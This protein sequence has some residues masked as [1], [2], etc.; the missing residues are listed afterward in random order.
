MRNATTIEVTACFQCRYGD[1]AECD[2]ESC[3]CNINDHDPFK[4]E[5]EEPTCLY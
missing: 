3:L 2:E 1:C 5:Q 4:D